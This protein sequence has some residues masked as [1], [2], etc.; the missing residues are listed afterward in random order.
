MLTR[1]LASMLGLL[2]ISLATRCIV[3]CR[4]SICIELIWVRIVLTEKGFIEIRTLV[5]LNLQFNLIDRMS[6]TWHKYLVS[7]GIGWN[8][9]NPA[10]A[11]A[12]NKP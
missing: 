12:D 3:I 1:M 8:R 10:A 11:A 2:L 5:N 4:I 9:K 6:L 7:H